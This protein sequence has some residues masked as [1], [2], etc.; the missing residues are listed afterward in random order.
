MNKHEYFRKWTLLRLNS[1]EVCLR[2][3]KEEGSYL[4][5]DNIDYKDLSAKGCLGCFS[6]SKGEQK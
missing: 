2:G 1:R 6:K 3:K 4:C 5:K